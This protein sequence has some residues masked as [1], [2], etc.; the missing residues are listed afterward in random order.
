M[1]HRDKT[2]VSPLP[3]LPRGICAV[4]HPD[5]T[6]GRLHLAVVGTGGTLCVLPIQPGWE[7]SAPEGPCDHR[8]CSDCLEALKQYHAG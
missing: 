5:P 8:Q 4:G 1:Q 6:Q 2:R 3:R 7:L